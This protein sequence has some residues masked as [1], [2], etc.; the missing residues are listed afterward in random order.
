MVVVGEEKG[1]RSETVAEEQL[2]T[3]RAPLDFYLAGRSV[4]K[5]RAGGGM[6]FRT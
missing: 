2:G 4:G 6:Q 5:N 3:E 1:D